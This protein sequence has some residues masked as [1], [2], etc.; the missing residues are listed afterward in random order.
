MFVPKRLA[1]GR[2]EERICDLYRRYFE[3]HQ[4]PLK[5]TSMIWKSPG[6]FSDFGWTCPPSCASGKFTKNHNG[7]S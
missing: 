3:R 1:K 6:R 2:L 7:G 4:V 5:Y